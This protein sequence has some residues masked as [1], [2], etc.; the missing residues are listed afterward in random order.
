MKRFLLSLPAALSVCA[1][2]A[3]AQT[4]HADPVDY[5]AGFGSFET[6]NPDA[7]L[8]FN[9]TN[10]SFSVP[11]WELRRFG[12]FPGPSTPSWPNNSE[13]AQDG[14]RY[15]ILRSQGGSTP[16]NSS[17]RFDFSLSP[18]ALTPGELYELT[19]WAAGGLASSGLNRLQVDVS[20]ASFNSFQD[21]YVLPVATQIDPLQWQEYS[22][23][24]TPNFPG[25]QLF[26]TA[27]EVNAGGSSSM[28]LDNFSLRQIPEPGSVVLL[29]AAA[30]L[31]GLRRRRSSQL[32]AGRRTP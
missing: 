7:V 10:S 18:V 30:G 27:L 20:N 5:F 21:P 14:D 26:F 25:V 31:L 11:G 12:D 17:A 8:D 28:Y 15:L 32:C 6:S 23:T 4:A 2:F 19:F 3:S 16:S 22:L 9:G 1:V 13:R 24:F 29:G